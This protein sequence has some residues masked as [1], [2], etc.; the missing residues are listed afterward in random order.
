[1]GNHIS[2]LSRKLHI[3]CLFQKHNHFLVQNVGTEEG[4]R[5]LLGSHI[6]GPS[7]DSEDW[8]NSNGS[9]EV[10]KQVRM[11][12]VE[13]IGFDEKNK[14]K[15]GMGNGDEVSNSGNFYMV[16]S[17]TDISNIQGKGNRLHGKM[18]RKTPVCC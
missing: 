6:F 16:L 14:V 1:M 8:G 3:Y 17:L 18:W 10:I 4:E 15:G 2:L 7:G 12:E 9:E 5:G 11:L 13:P